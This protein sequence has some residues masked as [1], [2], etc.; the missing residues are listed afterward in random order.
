VFGQVAHDFSAATRLIVG[1]RTEHVVVDGSGVK[2]RWRKARNT[3]DPLVSFQPSF[4][5][6][7]VGGKVTLEHALSPQVLGFASW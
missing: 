2:S 5:E 4:E 7:V 3:F 1:L 6:H